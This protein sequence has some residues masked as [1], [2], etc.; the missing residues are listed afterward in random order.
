MGQH[1]S[2]EDARPLGEALAALAAEGLVCQIVMVDGQ[3]VH[4]SAAPPATWREVR[5][6]TPAGMVTLVGRG[7]GP[8]TVFGNADAA[9]LEA[10]DRIARAFE[11][12]PG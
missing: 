1:T 8:V 5:L 6:R 4:P 12:P 3:L 10:R 11:L 9:L 2:I 7:G